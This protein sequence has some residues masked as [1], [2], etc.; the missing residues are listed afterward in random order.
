MKI[1]C[2]AIVMFF[3]SSIS[4]HAFDETMIPQGWPHVDGKHFI[5][6]YPQGGDLRGAN[7]ILTKAEMY[8]DR[9]S[10]RLGFARYGD[11][12]TWE[13]RVKIILY[14]DAQA[15]F[16][17]TNQP[18]WSEGFATTHSVNFGGRI[19]V[20]YQGQQ[21][22]LESI[23]PH[24]IGHLVLHDFMRNKPIPVFLDEGV[25]QLEEVHTASQ[26]LVMAQLVANRQHIPFMDIVSLR[27]DGRFDQRA[28]SIFYA[29]SLYIVDFL[30]KTYGKD[31]FVQLCRLL[32][33]GVG[34]EVAITKVYYP[35]VLN[36]NHLE[37]QWIQY[38]S[39]GEALAQ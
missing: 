21:N 20:S 33:D 31:S 19:I 6:V 37:K 23:L 30:I 16:A 24:E 35:T 5:V 29:E 1:L 15:F 28:V 34:I 3:L 14:N 36:L 22:F 26:R 4:I 38:L 39:I 7:E 11:Y 2:C 25:A 8:Y 17:Q 12:W 32:R 13:N 10:D 27:L 18:E 9:I